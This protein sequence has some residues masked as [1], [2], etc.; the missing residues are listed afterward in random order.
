[1]WQDL[2]EVLGK[3][4]AVYDDL[5]RIGE[6]K[7]D[8]LVKVDMKDLA[9]ILDEEQ[10]AAAKIENLEKKRG[11]ILKEL[12]KNFK[13]VNANTKA[14]DFYKNAPSVAIRS[15]LTSLHGNLTKSVERA[16][17]LRDNNQVLAQSALNAVKFHLNKL[18]GATINPTYGKQGG[19]NV[20][21]EKNFDFK[22]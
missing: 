12:S 15:K 3:I 16:V 6:R 14:M 7:R 2:I 8:A 19:A 20:T 17:M 22:A 9:K 4:C 5:G 10:L 13:N 21:H 11:A 1:M 18:S